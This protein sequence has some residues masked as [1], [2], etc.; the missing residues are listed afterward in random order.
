MKRLLCA[1]LA[2]LLMMSVASAAVKPDWCADYARV[3][4]LDCEPKRYLVKVEGDECWTLL[5]ADGGV[6]QERYVMGFDP[7]FREGLS[8]VFDP[9]DVSLSGFMNTAGELITGFDFYNGGWYCD[10]LF[11]EGLCCVQFAST[12]T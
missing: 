6:L 9:E 7:D 5:D 12:G 11:S 3:L 10:H 1:A 2:V 8:I 4:P